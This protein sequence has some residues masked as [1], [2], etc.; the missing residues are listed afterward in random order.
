VGSDVVDEFVFRLDTGGLDA[1][2]HRFGRH[3]GISRRCW[4][5]RGACGIPWRRRRRERIDLRHMR[6]QHAAVG[7]IPP[8]AQFRIVELSPIGLLATDDA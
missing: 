8:H 5:R 6:V 7:E 2:A 4:L 3:V 1:G